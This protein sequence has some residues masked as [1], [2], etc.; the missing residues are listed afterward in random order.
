[1]RFMVVGSWSATDPRLRE[2]L[3]AEQARTREL[4]E[5]GLVQ[6]L[7]LRADGVGAF[8]IVEG[9]S[10]DV[11]RTELTT[12]PLMKHDVMRIELIE[13]RN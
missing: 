1:M 5:G 8:M 2:L 10:A 12:L 4:T 11:V 7:L 13:L 3:E 6:Q 9:E